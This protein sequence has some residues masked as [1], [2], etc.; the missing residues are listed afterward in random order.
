MTHSVR[1]HPS[2]RSQIFQLYDYIVAESGRIRAGAW[3][4][5]IEASCLR[6]GAFPEMGRAA[7]HLGPGLRL[8]PIERRAM[9]VYRVTPDA[10]EVLGIYYGG[11][12]L[13]AL[14]PGP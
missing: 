8:H 3:I 2:A 10:V 1:F 14:E 13:S 5:R 12:D 9:I 7:D 11:R 6:L 4:D